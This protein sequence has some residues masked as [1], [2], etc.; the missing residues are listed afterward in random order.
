MKGEEGHL[1][2][3]GKRKSQE[4]PGLLNQ[5]DRIFRAGDK[6]PVGC[7]GVVLRSCPRVESKVE[8]GNQHNKRTDESIDKELDRSSNS[9]APS[10]DTNQKVHGNQGELKKH[11]EDNQI[12]CSKDAQRSGLQNQEHGVE[13]GRA[14]CRERVGKRE[15]ERSGEE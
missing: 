12:Q 13:I 15:G 9:V 14:S 1:N 6:A 8:Q 7:K 3:D 10:P 4:H 11:I 2:T 5:P